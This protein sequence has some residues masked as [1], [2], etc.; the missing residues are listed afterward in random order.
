M[1]HYDLSKEAKEAFMKNC[2]SDYGGGILCLRVDKV[3]VYLEIL[4]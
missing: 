3:N 1:E 4:Q 2:F